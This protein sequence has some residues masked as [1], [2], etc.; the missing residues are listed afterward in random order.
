[1]LGPF[2][3]PL[4]APINSD[5]DMVSRPSL[6]S[7]TSYFGTSSSYLEDSYRLNTGRSVSHTDSALDPP[8]TQL[9]SQQAN[10]LPILSLLT[11]QYPE[12]NDRTH[13]ASS[14]SFDASASSLFTP[15]NAWLESNS[16]I[17]N[18]SR[19]HS[20][21]YE[22]EEH[23]H[24][25]NNDSR[26]SSMTFESVALSRSRSL[27]QP[28]VSLSTPSVVNYTMNSQNSFVQPSLTGPYIIQQSPIATNS[29]N[30]N[31]LRRQKTHVIAAC[32]N[33]KRAHLACDI[34]RPCQRCISLGK[35]D[36]C[37]D[38]RHKKRG[39]PRLK[40]ESSTPSTSASTSP[41]MPTTSYSIA[42]TS[43]LNTSQ[44]SV[45]ISSHHDAYNSLQ[46]NLQSKENQS[47]FRTSVLAS[48]E[49]A[50]GKSDT[51]WLIVMPTKELPVIHVNELFTDRYP[52]LST[53]NL[54]LT[55]LFRTNI[56]G[57]NTLFTL[58]RPY[59]TTSISEKMANELLNSTF[60]DLMELVQL[61]VKPEVSIVNEIYSGSSVM[62]VREESKSLNTKIK[63]GYVTSQL[64][65]PSMT[66]QW[67]SSVMNKL[68]SSF[69][70]S[71][72]PVIS[73]LL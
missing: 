32:S 22:R 45:T 71:Y 18:I 63:V 56:E 33:C 20:L 42:T 62:S 27:P 8:N 66:C 43:F 13:D 10:K 72:D 51:L 39:R 3:G 68:C 52:V 53:S 14:E 44:G 28:S 5:P 37:V 40:E 67:D 19:S 59:I 64:V 60:S 34:S 24:R 46:S 4:L 58:L 65:Y 17:V 12:N 11:R 41:L 36:T 50:I 70:S 29:T 2:R 30:S 35:Q 1:M 31:N 47:G 7:L 54:S 61:N 23:Y 48:D 15:F 38:V 55:D 9:H 73:I 6:P 25:Y 21:H 69:C 16:Q 57:S 49:T 26:A